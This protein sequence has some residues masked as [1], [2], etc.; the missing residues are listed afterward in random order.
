VKKTFEIRKYGFIFSIGVSCLNC[1]RVCCGLS[2]KVCI[3][4]TC[5]FRRNP[6]LWRN[7][8]DVNCKTTCIPLVPS[9]DDSLRRNSVKYTRTLVVYSILNRIEL[10]TFISGP[11]I[12]TILQWYFW[13]KIANIWSCEDKVFILLISKSMPWRIIKWMCKWQ[14]RIQIK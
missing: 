8:H 2:V 7:I 6:R 10:G 4:E 11:S 12:L 5:W 13:L 14:I 1:K 3:T 9:L